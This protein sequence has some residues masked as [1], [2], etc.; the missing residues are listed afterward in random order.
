MSF[1]FSVA[2]G[3]LVV[4]KLPDEQVVWRG[5]LFGCS[6][7][8]YLALPGGEKCVV[9]LSIKNGPKLYNGGP[10]KAFNNLVCVDSLGTI[11]WIA[12]LPITGVDYFTMV[13]WMRN[14]STDIFVA[15]LTLQADA[16][17]AFSYSGYLVSINPLNGQIIDKLLIK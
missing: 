3:E 16:L 1:D 10:L 15:K 12:E 6:V 2:N 17:V 9:L 11:L 8:N 13:D 14:I 7:D 5:R 4:K